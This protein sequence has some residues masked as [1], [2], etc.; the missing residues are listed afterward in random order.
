MGREKHWTAEGNF[1]FIDERV[2]ETA[3]E[4]EQ[5]GGTRTVTKNNR[6]RHTETCY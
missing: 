2:E 5:K 6:S 4:T 3:H 1:V